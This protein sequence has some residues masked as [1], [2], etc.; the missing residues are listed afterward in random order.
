VR[1]D[2]IVLGA[3]LVVGVAGC[4][5][6]SD[7]KSSSG[8]N[9]G[10]ATHTQVPKD[11][12]QG[13]SVTFLSSGDVDYLDPGQDYYTF[14]F[15]VQYSVNRPLYSY[16]PSNSIT[17]VPD[18]ADSEPEVSAD[19]KTITIHIRKGIKYAP[20]VNREVTSADVKYAIERAFTTSVPSG[21]SGVYFSDIVGAPA[22]P[23]K[24]SEL[25]DF[26]GL[27]TP[28]DQTL[29]IK[30]EE[31]SAPIVV[32]A[33]VLPISV[34]VPREYAAKFDKKAPSEY[35]SYVA[36]TGPYM[37][38]NDPKSGKVTGRKAGK[39]VQIVRNPNWDRS[40]DFRP[41]YLDSMTISEGNSDTTVSV[42]RTTQGS[43]LMCCDSAHPPP[44]L[45]KKLLSTP[46]LF[47]RVPSG[48]LHWDSLNMRRKPLTN[49]NI[50]KAIIAGMD[51]DAYRKTA[52]GA[53]I[54]PIAQGYIPPG[55]PGFEESGGLKGFTDL[56]WMQYPTGNA[57]VARKYMN[58][59]AK[60]GLRVEN[61][62]YAG[63]EQLDLVVANTPTAL[64]GAELVQAQLGKLGFKVK[65]R[66]LPQDTLYT[67]F[68]GVP[69]NDPAICDGVGWVKDFQDPQ[70]MLQATFTGAAIKPNGNVNWSLLD[71]PAIDA[72][73]AKAAKLPVGS[74]RNR[75][76]A[77]VNKL[78]LEQ[79]PTIPTTWDDNFQMQSKDVNGVINAYT[80]SWDLNYSSVK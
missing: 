15:M 64:K 20:P 79:A 43:H 12:K 9:I 24:Y 40:T 3:V 25:K 4:G 8:S 31:P 63:K 60:D 67:K 45:L 47:G 80:T 51:R 58:L 32:G 53:A 38:K 68:C 73:L 49:L 41:A 76:F 52:G 17:P 56:D 61:G 18:L 70:T 54:G 75:A 62:K 72:A 36:F 21:Y 1:R 34:P 66:Q 11:A 44:N 65:I 29:V 71:D 59:A 37:V 42:R 6:S 14:G 16:K 33:L 39:S 10:H 57:A 27:Q 48:G 35:D 2:L 26:P 78:I 13:G 46:A 30:L 77:G 7:S 55:M 22:A 69:K 23:V 50:R 5:S 74:A 19:G 28:D